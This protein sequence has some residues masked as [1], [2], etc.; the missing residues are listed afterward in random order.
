MPEEQEGLKQGLTIKDYEDAITVQDACNL[1]G[2][3]HSFS[4]VISKIWVE[5]RK[6]KKGTEWVNQHPISKMYSDKILHL[7]GEC[8]MNTYLSCERQVEELKKKETLSV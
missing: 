7:A 6:E 5:A 2:V 4:R 1:S 3:V 8:N